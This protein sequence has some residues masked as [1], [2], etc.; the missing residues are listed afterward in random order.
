MTGMIVLSAFTG[1]AAFDHP[2]QFALDEYPGRTSLERT[3]AKAHLEQNRARG[4]AANSVCQRSM[5]SREELAAESHFDCKAYVMSK[6]YA[7]QDAGIDESRM[8]VARIDF[9]IGPHVVLVV[10][11]R[12]VLDNN[13]SNV[14]Q[15]D[16]YALFAPVL[17]R[18]PPILMER[19]PWPSRAMFQDNRMPL[20]DWAQLSGTG[21]GD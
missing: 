12:Y 17:A 2:A 9:A 3:I 10:D 5:P 20:P 14:R 21:S 19:Q 11:E 4:C 6:A 7:L 8:R 1:C 13:D 16:E 18:L 15:W